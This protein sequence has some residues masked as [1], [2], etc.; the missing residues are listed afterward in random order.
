M[1]SEFDRVWKEGIIIWFKVRQDCI[2]QVPI[3]LHENLQHGSHKLP[4]SVTWLQIL[5]KQTNTGM[6][7]YVAAG[8]YW[9]TR[10]RLRAVFLPTTSAWL[11][12]VTSTWSWRLSGINRTILSRIW[13]KGPE[14]TRWNYFV[15]LSEIVTSLNARHRFKAD[16][17]AVHIRLR[18]LGAV[19]CVGQI[20]HWDGNV[21]T[22]LKV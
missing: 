15:Y 12:N 6:S 14:I 17:F 8:T 20:M 19:N 11:A 7:A 22:K 5:R 16:P 18:L 4:T 21:N 3:I 1:H 9:P 10:T 13:L 2:H